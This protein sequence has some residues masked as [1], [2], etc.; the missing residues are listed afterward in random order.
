MGR[1]RRKDSSGDGIKREFYDLRSQESSEEKP[2]TS[3]ASGETNDQLPSPGGGSHTKKICAVKRV[4]GAQRQTGVFTNTYRGSGK[5]SA[6][7]VHKNREKGNKDLKAK[8]DKQTQS[9]NVFFPTIKTEDKEPNC[10]E[11]VQA[12]ESNDLQNK[13]EISQDPDLTIPPPEDLKLPEMF[14][15]SS[16]ETPIALQHF[17]TSGGT[18]AQIEKELTHLQY[19]PSFGGT[20]AQIQQELT[21]LQYFPSSGGT[22]APIQQELTHLQYFPSSGGTPAHIQQELTHLQ[23]FPSSGGTPAQI[24]QELTHLQYFPSSGGTPAQ[25]QQEL[26]HLQ[27][28]PSS[29][30]TSAQIHKE[31]TSLQYF[32]SSERTPDPIKQEPL[33]KLNTE[34]VPF[35]LPPSGRPYQQFDVNR[36]GHVKRPMNAFMIWA[37]IH[38]PAL[39]RANP[40]ASNASISIHL[41]W[42]WS[43]LTEKQKNPYY[44]EAW[45]LKVKHSQMFPDWTYMPRLGKDK[46]PPPNVNNKSSAVLLRPPTSTFMM[47]PCT[48][49]TGEAITLPTNAVHSV[50]TPLM[51]PRTVA[52]SITP[53][54]PSPPVYTNYLGF[55]A[56]WF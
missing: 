48:Q 47:P 13:G 26:T 43:K 5:R 9:K 11:G 1:G 46:K 30:G 21:H 20:T 37:R 12:E 4:P 42:E 38:R 14:S 35:T 52:A 17:T 28:F 16:T 45:K 29:V 33:V 2:R 44:L 27:Y 39:A 51:N 15:A 18:P 53:P 23:Y 54:P 56:V 55:P 3:E 24:Q 34:N 25:I 22:P 49:T 7:H 10:T 36:S 19:F 31:P 50:S 41:G 40:T 8:E 6:Q 32:P